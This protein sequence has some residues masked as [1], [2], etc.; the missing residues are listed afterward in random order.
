MGCNLTGGLRLPLL[1]LGLLASAAAPVRAL[2]DPTQPIDPTRRAEI[3]TKDAVR[4]G[5]GTVKG[6]GVVPLRVIRMSELPVRKVELPAHGRTPTVAEARPKV[7]IQKKNVRSPAA[8]TRRRGEVKAARD[9]PASIPRLRRER[10]QKMITE[11]RRGRI[12][13]DAFLHD[14]IE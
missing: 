9:M 2:P 1:C 13:A 6:D 8:E 4:P 11:Y 10:F 5:G 12:P 7:V 14:S 3:S